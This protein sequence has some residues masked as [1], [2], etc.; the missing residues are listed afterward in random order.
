MLKLR[1][2]FLA[3]VMACSLGFATLIGCNR[4]ETEVGLDYA[5]DDLLGL[6]QT[7]TLT[8]R[9]RTVREDSLQSDNLSTAVLGR[10][11][12]PDF[13]WHT[14]GFVT[15]FRLSAPDID[16]G[17]NP[18]V[19]S[20]YL[21]LRYTGDAY[22]Q[23]SPQTIDVYALEDSL[24]YDSTYYSNHVFAHSIE[25]LADPGFQ[26]IPLNPNQTLYFG[27]DTVNPEARIY[28]Q[29][30][31]GQLL[32]DAG[33]EVYDSNASWN[34][35]FRGLRITPNTLMG[36]Q[37]AVGIDLISGLSYMRLHYHNDS[38]TTFYDYIINPLSA[39]SNQFSHE[40]QG[41]FQAL[42]EPLITEVN[43]PLLG[44]FSGAG[45]KTQITF[46]HLSSWK[47][48]IGSNSAIHK[49]ELWLPVE[50]GQNDA[51]YPLPRQLFVL[52]EDALGEAI[53][54]PDQSSIGLNINGNFDS[55]EQAYRFNISQTLQRMLNGDSDSDV[56]NVVSS[57]A[58]ISFQGIA[59]AGPTNPSDSLPRNARLV[60][61]WSD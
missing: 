7:D 60:V 36:G 29:D 31:F 3:T 35:F 25:N 61:T 55:E 15:Q 58:G 22:G 56:L 6:S 21:S 14:A 53:S 54:T 33:E 1:A 50:P 24:E 52:T 30:A 48:A 43:Q 45:L 20:V 41:A 10:M 42:S 17:S 37:G 40:W 16:F 13:G 57:R 4:P 44:V 18:Q 28:L 34:S 23:L 26:P 59:I 38:D 51:H 47:E 5:E 32:L 49:A 12:H 11:Y 46:P 27:N 39:R 8:L 2:G 9:C 19:D